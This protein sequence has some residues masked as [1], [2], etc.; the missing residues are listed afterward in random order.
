MNTYRFLTILF[1]LLTTN[2]FYSL[3]IYTQNIT[4]DLWYIGWF[5][6]STI[7]SLFEGVIIMFIYYI[8]IDFIYR[9]KLSYK[10]I[11]FLTLFISLF[12]IVIWE[13]SYT[14]VFWKNIFTFI[15]YNFDLLSLFL[16]YTIWIWWYWYY[17]KYIKKVKN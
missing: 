3:Y 2:V 4:R 13:I 6:F 7:L 16:I 5:V 1:S 10:N 9:L 12:F 14:E 11:Y 17:L 15:I 8:F